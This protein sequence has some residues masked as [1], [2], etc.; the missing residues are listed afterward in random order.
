MSPASNGHRHLERSKLSTESAR[1]LLY[2]NYGFNRNYETA[3]SCTEAHPRLPHSGGRFFLRH[4]QRFLFC[5]SHN[6]NPVTFGFAYK[7]KRGRTSG[8]YRFRIAREL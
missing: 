5:H 1:F 4:L 8:L 3:R 6:S 7:D 2:G